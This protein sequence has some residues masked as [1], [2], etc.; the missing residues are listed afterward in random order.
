MPEAHSAGD[1][2]SANS[3]EPSDPIAPQRIAISTFFIN[4]ILAF[5]QF[6]KA[7]DDVQSVESLNNTKTVKETDVRK[8]LERQK[9]LL[10]NL[11]SFRSWA[12]GCGAHRGAQEKESLDYKL[13]EALYVHDTVTGLLEELNV[14]LEKGITLITIGAAVEAAV[15]VPP[16]AEAG[17]ENTNGLVPEEDE[18]DVEDD[19][20]WVVGSTA[21]CGGG[22]DVPEGPEDMNGGP[23]PTA[24]DYALKDISHIIGCLH[25]LSAST[26]RQPGLR[27]RLSRCGRINVEHFRPWDRAHIACKFPNAPPYLVDRLGL[28]NTRRRQLLKYH[29]RHHDKIASSI[30]EVAGGTGRGVPAVAS[31]GVIPTRQQDAVEEA[32]GRIDIVAHGHVQ[33]TAAGTVLSGTVATTLQPLPEHGAAPTGWED[34]LAFCDAATSAS[35]ATSYT[36]GSTSTAS[37]LAPPDCPGEASEPFTCPYCLDTIILKNTANAWTDHIYKDILPYVCTFADCALSSKL[38]ASR[39]EWFEHERHAHRQEW[40]CAICTADSRHDVEAGHDASAHIFASKRQLLQHF[41]LAHAGFLQGGHDSDVGRC[42]RDASSGQPCPLVCAPDREYDA[43]RLRHHVGQHM[44]QMALFVLPYGDPGGESAAR[45]PAAGEREGLAA[46]LQQLPAA[47]AAHD[48]PREAPMGA[49]EGSLGPDEDG[50]TGPQPEGREASASP[51]ARRDVPDSERSRLSIAIIEASKS[52]D[53]EAVKGLLAEGANAES[54]DPEYGQTPLSWAAEKGQEGVVKLLLEHGVDV[55]A[56]DMGAYE[57]SPLSW[58]AGNGREGVVKL[59]LEHGADVEAK[60]N[61]GQSPLSWAA[62]RGH[63]GVVKLLLEHGA[64]IEAR[65]LVGIRR[66]PLLWAAAEGHEVVVRVLLEH[67]ADIETRDLLGFGRTP[68]LSAAAEGHEGVVRLLLEHG[69]DIEAKSNNGKSPLSWAAG[70]GHEG[71][72]KLL[73]EHGAD[74]NGQSPI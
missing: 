27:D 32:P 60:N 50:V 66:T 51:V 65:D 28:A 64:D 29:Q 12:G 68:L 55:E 61:N 5:Q 23:G 34:D 2:P 57:Q 59:L 22:N 62:G 73:L 13:R 74:D 25:R 4:C 37:G 48:E 17:P 45:M 41:R 11:D 54:R 52:G 44:Q 58:A 38:F 14:V 15:T 6:L 42:H 1:N 30:H 10:V 63:E 7:C 69:A 35:F 36:A 8:P 39:T 56:R 20:S 70:R 9:Q 16:N 26:L 33:G 21:E 3:E 46:Y 49:P 18:S 67:G 47:F 24:L 31:S 53:G 19:F 71:V 40:F 72:V 43:V